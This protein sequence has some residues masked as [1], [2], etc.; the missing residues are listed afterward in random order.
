MMLR[1]VLASLA[2]APLFLSTASARA[3]QLA[4]RADSEDPEK[5]VEDSDLLSL[6]RDLCEI[7]SISDNEQ[8]VGEFLVE[9]LESQD[10]TVKKQDV[11]HE[12][13]DAT[14]K[15]RF[16][17][18]AY[19]KGGDEKDIDVI[20]TTH[21]DTV[22]PHIDYKVSANETT[23]KR[24]DIF[25]S[26]RGTVDA[27]AG[28]AAQTIAAIKYLEKNPDTK[29]GLLFVVG[30]ESSGS[31]INAFSE[32]DL[33]PD[34]TPYKAFIFAEPTNGKLASGHKGMLSFTVNVTG[35]AGHSGYPWLS[36]SAVSAALPILSRLDGLG[37]ASK[38][39]GG[40][41]RNDKYGNSTINIGKIEAGAAS[42]VVP[43]SAIAECSIRIAEGTPKEVEKIVSKAVKEA[44]E[45][46]DID[47]DRV[48]VTFKT[49]EGYAPVEL[50]A[51]V[52]GFDVD[53]MHYGTDIP[54]LEIKGDAKVKIFLYGPGSIMVAH[55]EDEGLTVGQLEDSL[56]AYS[57]LID[58]ALE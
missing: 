11:E 22:P 17:V 51:E 20:L 14:D 12:S 29:L 6:H 47:E 36:E 56:E 46:H 57:K 53:V 54:G 34:P 43:A 37:E 10:F 41:P 52:D 58:A 21:I 3:T 38:E 35:V 24:E 13:D 42:N 31:G 32:S 16:N 4:P 2:F 23:N 19:P 33:N 40:L 49:D 26:G 7:K 9:Y 44:C 25:I 55:G 15:E 39:D 5:V 8:E 48:T 28:V 1:S 27:K 18:F 30:E 45:E 50:D